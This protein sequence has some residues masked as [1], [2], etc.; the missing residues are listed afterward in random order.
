M[1]QTGAGADFFTAS[2]KQAIL[3]HGP[4]PPAPRRDPKNSA[5]GKLE[6]VVLG[7]RLFYEPRLSGTGSVL[8]ATCHVPYRAWQDG[9]AKG[10]GLEQSDRNT[11]TLL[12]VAFQ[13]RFGWDGARD[14]LAA[15]SIR[16]LL[17]AREMRTSAAQVSL[18]IKKHFLKG[19]E[20][21]F[22]RSPPDDDTELLADVGKALAAFQETLVSGRTP[23]DE[24]RDA[25]ESQKA[26]SYPENAKRGLKIFVGK[27]GCSACHSGP[28]FTN[29]ERV[30]FRVPGLRN[31]ALTAPYLHDGRLPAL[32]DAARHALK[33]E[34]LTDAEL[35][36][37]VIFLQTLSEI[38]T[39]DIPDCPTH[40]PDCRR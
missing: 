40:R 30:E 1:A 32:S 17:D 23:F 8:C 29:G 27:G 25:L 33:K 20:K 36:D 35:G 22:G 2:E 15:Q 16:P 7:E 9:R 5:S 3:A 18:L 13:R 34:F 26:N 4:W 38:R 19:Y 12:N 24:F 21:A 11:P 14:S 37:L 39:F 6:A 28:L 31:V 10:F